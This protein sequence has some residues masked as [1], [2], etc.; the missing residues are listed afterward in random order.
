MGNRVSVVVVSDSLE[1]LQMA[2]MVASVSAVSGNEVF[3][4]LSMN[5]LAPFRKGAPS[6]ADPEGEF[7][8]AMAQKKVPPFKQLFESAVQL[9]D[10]KI[11]PCSMAMDILGYGMDDLEPYLSEHMGLTKFL[12]EAATGQIWTF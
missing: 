4:F 9:G 7:G 8:K 12:D 2:G 1:R 11:F 6:H 5:A 3:V 10:A